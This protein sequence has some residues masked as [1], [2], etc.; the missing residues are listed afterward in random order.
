MKLILTSLISLTIGF[1]CLAQSYNTKSTHALKNET[2]TTI[3]SGYDAYKKI[4]LNMSFSLFASAI[5]WSI[6]QNL[7]S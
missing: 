5:Y 6:A 2:A 4:A 1:N 7:L 3:Q